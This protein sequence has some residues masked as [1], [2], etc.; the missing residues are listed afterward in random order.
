[1]YEGFAELERKGWTDADLAAGYVD[2]FAP[3]SDMAIPPL[4]AGIG[5]G[6]RVL[7]LCCGQGNVSAALAAAGAEPVGVDFSP[8][9]LAIAR[10][11]VPG[12]E[13]IEGD[14]QDL[15]FPDR[16]FDA[17]V[18]N[19]GLVHVPD[20]ARALAEVARVLKPGGRFAM[21]GWSGPDVSPTFKLFYGAVMAHGDP[22][23]ALP[24]GP[25]F[26]AYADSG[27]VD[28]MFQAAGLAPDAPSQIDCHF[29]MGDPAQLVEIF[30]RGAPRGG[31]LLAKQPAA[32]KEAIRG[33][34]ESGVRDGFAHGDGW[35][36]PIPAALC[37]ARREV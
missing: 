28:G 22:D 29:T 19:F 26:H 32:N 33:A 9:M 14:A 37:R 7:D 31:Y 30:Q 36:V 25:N 35:R 8:A 16:D 15:P 18:C 1:M 12:V 20:Q 13:F 5:P 3:A 10:D 11:R 6:Q 2:L 17:V 23:V 24:E 4:I 34:I 27:W 21:T